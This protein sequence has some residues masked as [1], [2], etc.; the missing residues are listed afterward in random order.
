MPKYEVVDVYGK[1][2]AT[3]PSKNQAVKFKKQ[4]TDTGKFGC[5]VLE[6]KEY[7]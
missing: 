7:K 2:I 6:K 5:K 1:V 3:F 4:C